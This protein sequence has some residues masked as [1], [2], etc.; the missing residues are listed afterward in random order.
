MLARLE[1][2]VFGFVQ[3]VGFRYFV[4]RN[5]SRLGLSGFVENLP[6]G[7]VAVIAEG[8]KEDLEALLAILKKGNINAVIKRVD[9]AFK[10]AKNEFVEFNIF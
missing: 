7:S 3:G 5:A 1:A 9:Y 2:R 6:D 4:K 8:K 10:E